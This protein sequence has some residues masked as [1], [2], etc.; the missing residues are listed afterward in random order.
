MLKAS[1]IAAALVT[2]IAMPTYAATSMPT[3]TCD[4]A[5]MTTLQSKINDIPDAARKTTATNEM[6]LAKAAVRADKIKDCSLHM[7]NAMK[8]I[9]DTM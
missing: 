6:T 3:S 9:G 2:A 7:D 4:D 5:S 1:L 8:A